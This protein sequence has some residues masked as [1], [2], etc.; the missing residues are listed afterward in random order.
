MITVRFE[1][2]KRKLLFIWRFSCLLSFYQALIDLVCG[3]MIMERKQS[4][5][6]YIGHIYRF[7]LGCFYFTL[8]K[9]L[10]RD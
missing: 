6:F 2:K 8:Q 3:L 10:Y 5:A 1:E 4:Y 7:Y 9:V